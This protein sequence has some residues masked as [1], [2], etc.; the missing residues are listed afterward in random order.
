[1]DQPKKFQLGNILTISIAHMVHDIYSSFLAPLLPLLIEKLQLSYSLAGLL[2]IAQRIPSLFNPLVGIAADKIQVRYLL[3]IAPSITAV[4]MS[5]LGA[6]PQYTI[7]FILLF[8]MGIGASLFHVPAPVMVRRIAGSRIGKGMSLFMFGGEIARS[9]GPLII[10][11]AVSIWGLEGTYKLIP[12][13]L[14]A[15]FILFLKFRNI[16]IS[17][18]LHT[19]DKKDGIKKTFKN[20]LPFFLILS[21]V[22]FF[23]ALVK[24]SLTTFLPTFITSQGESIWAGGISLSILQVAGAAGTFTSGTISDKIGRKKTLLIMAFTTPV[25]MVMFVYL[26]GIF[27]IPLLILM[28]FFMFAGTPVLLAAVNE[29]KSEHPSF[30]NGVFMTLNFALSGVAVMTVGV[31]GDIVGLD[32]TY[33]ICAVLALFAIPFIIK[34]PV[35]NK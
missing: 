26:K 4:S 17:R 29:K 34:L 8:V 6:A 15:S 19:T 33:K 9:I 1:M 35:E 10:L 20:F 24:G 32:T 21:G 7:L 3:I 25:L 14:L 16:K 27:T 28:G 12:F 13:G 23:S 11:G 5:L 22:I 18:D 2:T 31:L 30:I